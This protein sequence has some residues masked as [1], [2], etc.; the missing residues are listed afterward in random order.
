MEDGRA[1]TA[2]LPYGIFVDDLH[3]PRDGHL[4]TEQKPTLV[5]CA[6]IKPLMILPQQL[7]YCD[8]RIRASSITPESQAFLIIQILSSTGSDM[9]KPPFLHPVLMAVK[10]KEI[11][12][13]QF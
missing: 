5:Q 7:T 9:V 6:S 1:D 3:D 8:S 2:L 13:L 10:T 4:A 11:L 12:L